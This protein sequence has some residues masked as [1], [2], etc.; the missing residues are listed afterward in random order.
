[1]K[2]YLDT[3]YMWSNF[4][5]T[6]RELRKNPDN[7]EKIKKS[8]LTSSKIKHLQDLR[9]DLFTSNVAKAEVFRKLKSEMSVDKKVAHTVWEDFLILFNIKELRIKKADFDEIAELCLTTESSKG[10]IFDLIQLQFAKKSELIF[11]TGEK[12]LKKYFSD[13]YKEIWLHENFSNEL[14]KMKISKPFS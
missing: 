2:V 14:S 8:I 9:A 4:E 7:Y 12:D 6:V 5:N 1:M 3:S 10:L 11:A 13:Y